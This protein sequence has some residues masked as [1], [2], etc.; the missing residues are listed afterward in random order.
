MGQLSSY[1]MVPTQIEFGD[2]FCV[3]LHNGE[4]QF[5]QY[6]AIDSTQ[7]EGDVIRVFEARY[8]SDFKPDVNCIVKD[9]IGCYALTVI[10]WGIASNSWHKYGH[11][12][13]IGGVSKIKFRVKRELGWF[14]WRIN[15]R[16]MWYIILPPWYRKLDRG[17]VCGPEAL[18]Y[19]LN[20]KLTNG[21]YNN[22]REEHPK[23]PSR[24]ETKP[25]WD[26][27]F[28]TALLWIELVAALIVVFYYIWNGITK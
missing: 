26:S 23:T 9:D 14:V 24:L 8:P 5:F 19:R 20:N 21:S 28:L 22:M 13:D 18:T 4:R 1:Q 17:Y 27:V 7:L 6:V 2:I 11:H 12:D 10:E 16:F 25:S 15:R 3:M